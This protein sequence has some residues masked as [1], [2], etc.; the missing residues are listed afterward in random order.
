M[1]RL[2]PI[3]Y[4]LEI[5]VSRPVRVAVGKLGALRVQAGRYVYTGSARRN[6][7]ARVSR[8]LTGGRS[9]RWHVDYLLAAPQ[10][11]IVGV[12]MSAV[13]ECRL[14]RRTPGITLFPGFGSSDCRKGCR[15]HLKYQGS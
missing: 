15:S 6:L 10:V 5:E 7:E 12:T 8:H 13:A 1:N 3:S 2:E 14:N 11:R 9:K 4:Q